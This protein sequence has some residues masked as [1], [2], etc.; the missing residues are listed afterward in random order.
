MPSL[1]QEG[2]QLPKRQPSL[3]SLAQ[4]PWWS[5]THQDT[6]SKLRHLHRFGAQKLKL[7]EATAQTARDVLLLHG[8]HVTCR[9]QVL[10]CSDEHGMRSVT[11]VNRKHLNN[12]GISWCCTN[13]AQGQEFTACL[14]N[15]EI[16]NL[17]EYSGKVRGKRHS[18]ISTERNPSPSYSSLAWSAAKPTSQASLQNHIGLVV[19][20]NYCVWRHVWRHSHVTCQC[21]TLYRSAY[22]RKK[23]YYTLQA[24]NQLQG[25]RL[26]LR[27]SRTENLVLWHK[28][29]LQACS[30]QHC[31]W[32]HQTASILITSITIMR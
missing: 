10:L 30:L 22:L 2:E 18:I 6:I 4:D 8:Q 13:T 11:K 29:G 16:S 26:P 25:G 23:S 3:L 12:C 15:G 32:V 17:S 14:S 19:S 9:A 1:E 27:W 7:P 28:Q 21:Y 24:R 5:G 20:T 31:Q